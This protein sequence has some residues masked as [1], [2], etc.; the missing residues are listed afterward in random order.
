MEGPDGDVGHR[1]A[2]PAGQTW[3][4]QAENLTKPTAVL[5]DCVPLAFVSSQV[6]WGP[7]D[8]L[9]VDMPPGTG[10]VQLSISQNIPVSGHR[11]RWKDGEACFS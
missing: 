1:E 10:D 11:R 9:V 5:I 6:E 4:V 7:L 2:A 8:Y 3:I